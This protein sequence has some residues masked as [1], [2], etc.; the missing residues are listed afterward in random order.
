MAVELGASR[1]L[2]PYFSSSQIVWTIIIGTIMIAMALGNIYGGRAADKNPEPDK[3]YGRIIVAAVWIALIPVLGKYIILGISAVMIFSVNNMF[4]IWAAFAA[5][6]VVFVF[7]LFL[8]GTVTPSL[9]KFTIDDL[10][11]SGKTVG[12]LNAFNTIGSII[13]TFV[14]TF[15]T[16]PAVGTSI[17]FLIFAGIL[18]VLAILYFI[19]PREG[20]EKSPKNR[21]NAVKVTAGIL[22]FLVSCFFG[23]SDSFAFWE[24][25]LTYE[26]ESVYNYLQVSE[27]DKRVYLSTNVLFGVQ[28]VY[29]KDGSLTGMYYDY[30]M[31]APY[32]AGIKEKYGLDMLIL[33][34][35]TGTYATQCKR[36]FTGEGDPD[37]RGINV[38]GVEIDEDITRLAREYFYLSEEIP[39][40]TYDGRAF[41]NAVD[42]TYDVIMVDAYQDITIPFQMS[43]VE[44]FT[45]VKDHLNPGGVMVVNMNMRGQKDDEGITFSLAQTISS[46]F[47][48]CYVVNC[49]GSSNRELFA[50]MDAGILDTMEKNLA[51]ETNLE[52]IGMMK[53]VTDH[54]IAFEH[55]SE[56]KEGAD[57]CVMTDDQA[58]VELLGMKVIDEMIAEEVGYYKDIFKKD[59]LQGLLDAFGN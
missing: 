1:L 57:Y 42:K 10:G 51:T 35:G 19:S 40:W 15:V 26:G 13:G 24:S 8:L 32:M 39:V 29:E 25:D 59:G 4:L 41:L 45:L 55:V 49:E 58:P 44:F 46:V 7:P 16:I 52:L 18:L 3:L 12:M 23:K 9:V 33:G 56:G 30:A 31:A 28:S 20:D 37:F 6:M 14:P 50:S 27:D 21:K 53:R 17:T 34:M 48:N 54:L 43:S 47:P 2:A 11:D 36:F 5:C 22:I 38:E